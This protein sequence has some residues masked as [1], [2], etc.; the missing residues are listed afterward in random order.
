MAELVR[1]SVVQVLL[2][3]LIAMP[4]ILAGCGRPKDVSMIEER[5]KAYALV[6]LA[7]DTSH[8]DANQQK[9]LMYLVE[10]AKA[11]DPIF[12]H[13]SAHEAPAAKAEL[14]RSKHPEDKV[15]L[16]YVLINYGPFDRRFENERFYGEGKPKPDGA[17]F[18]PH[19]LTKE[20]FETY[21]DAHPEIREDF[22][23]LNTLIRRKGLELVAVPF[24]REYRTHLENAAAAL[25]QAGRYADNPSLKQYLVLRA[26]ALLSGDFF[27]SD[28][29][30]MDLEDNLLDTVIG[31][32][33]VYED[34]LMGLKATYEAN[35][36]IK[37]PEAS[38]QLDIYKQYLNRLE[39]TLP[40]EEKYKRD[41]V[42]MGNKLEIVNIAYFAGDYNAGI[43]TIAT[44]LPNDARVIEAKGAKK[45]IYQNVLGA[46]FRMI[47][48]P[49]A[50][51]LVD[52]EQVQWVSEDA[53]VTNTLQHEISHTLG[54]NHVYGHEDL[55]IRKALQE[56]Y[57]R[58]EEC[59]ADIVGI[60]NS[61]YFRK[62]EVFTEEQVRRN[63]VT[64]LGGIFR[65]VRFG[66]ESA[67]AKGMAI[68]LNYLLKEGGIEYDTATGT[69]RV[70]FDEFPEA[71]DKL[72]GEVLDIEATG[73]YERAGEL[74]EA[75]GNLTPETL[76]S[77]DK[78]AHIPVDVRFTY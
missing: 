74:L 47:L 52:P 21:V 77:L 12:W 37:D 38:R 7:A 32:I 11:I 44:S 28:M 27:E 14:E 71:V 46:K 55:T 26:E 22:E 53:F 78:L 4:T 60:H 18:Y 31:P 51:V 25:R 42:G 30:W 3:V 8:L 17:G 9:V 41:S 57:S 13:Q 43:K 63:Y 29:A 56:R 68:Q 23:K 65:S 39:H 49:I 48:K 72:A 76:A 64:Y 34:Q 24:E 66:T 69:Y 33:E 5:L 73:D 20:E 58:I 61:A 6:D 75:Y 54:P 45:Q 15:I 67:H 19:N 16:E 62:V 2:V 70:N 36:A 50:E 1:R 10:A 59:K 35:V 40:M